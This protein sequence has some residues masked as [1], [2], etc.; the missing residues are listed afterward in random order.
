MFFG[1][2]HAGGNTESSQVDFGFTLAGV[3]QFLG[4]RPNDSIVQALTP[5]TQFGDTLRSSFRTKLAKYSI[6]NFWEKESSVSARP[7]SMCLLALGYGSNA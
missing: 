6:V 7:L 1:T 4:F 2:P 3:A 5:G